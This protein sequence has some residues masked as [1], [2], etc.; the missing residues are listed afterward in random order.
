MCVLNSIVAGVHTAESCCALCTAWEDCKVRPYTLH[1][2]CWETYTVNMNELPDE[3]CH[4]AG[5]SHFATL[6]P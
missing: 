2:A 5:N 6:T 3:K 1:A 4:L